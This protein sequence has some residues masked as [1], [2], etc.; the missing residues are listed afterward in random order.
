VREE[1]PSWPD[2]GPLPRLLAR[3]TPSRPTPTALTCISLL[4]AFLIPPVGVA[5]RGAPLVVV[6]INL[7]LTLLGWCVKSGPGEPHLGGWIGPREGLILFPHPS[8][9]SPSGSPASFTPSSPLR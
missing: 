6:L 9:L 3:P 4:W 5:L 7:L 2:I 1:A 8:L